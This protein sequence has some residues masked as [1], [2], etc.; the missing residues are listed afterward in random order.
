MNEALLWPVW[1]IPI[2]PQRLSEVVHDRARS[3]TIAGLS[4]FLPP[5][6]P[7]TI[8]GSKRALISPLKGPEVFRNENSKPEC[9]NSLSRVAAVLF[10]ILHAALGFVSSVDYQ[11]CNCV[12][13]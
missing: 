5:N 6:D 12:Y 7:D 8:M 2:F 1:I 13:F 11:T 4:L 9:I 3:V 10:E